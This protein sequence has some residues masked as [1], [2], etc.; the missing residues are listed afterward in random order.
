MLQ[1]IGCHASKWKDAL[2]AQEVRRE[3]RRSLGRML[4]TQGIEGHIW[5]FSTAYG[6][7]QRVQGQ[8]GETYTQLRA[9]LE[10]IALGFTLRG[11]RHWRWS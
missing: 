3:V 6:E 8:N 1:A 11:R 7:V 4:H 10:A 2:S 5:G 9:E